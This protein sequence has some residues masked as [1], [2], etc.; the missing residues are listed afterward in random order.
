MNRLVPVVVACL[1]TL[2]SLAAAKP[3]VNE[4]QACQGMLDFVQA[5]LAAAPANY[6]ADDVAK[7][8]DGLKRYNTYIQND[9]VTPGLTSYSGGNTEQVALLQQQVD[10]YKSAIADRLKAQYK[11]NRLVTDHAIAVNEC[12]K[13]A[14]PAGEDL[15]ALREAVVTMVKLARM[16]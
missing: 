11:Q 14:V 10:A 2:P 4:M 3:S 5:R 8:R 6:P 9:I 13:K 7:V 12:A 16:N 15:E 1:I